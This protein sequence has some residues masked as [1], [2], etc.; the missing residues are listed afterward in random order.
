MLT[1]PYK[2]LTTLRSTPDGSYVEKFEQLPSTVPVEY[3]SGNGSFGGYWVTLESKSIFQYETA[4]RWSIYACETGHARSTCKP[5]SIFF[6][7]MQCGSLIVRMLMWKLLFCRFRQISRDGA[8]QRNQYI[9]SSG[10][11]SGD[12]R[13]AVLSSGFLKN[14]LISVTT[15]TRR[16]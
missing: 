1:S 13:G 12:E 15:G 4:F 9:A 2:Q 7:K 3:H 14:A 6:K 11:D 8:K 10:E 5:I 16:N